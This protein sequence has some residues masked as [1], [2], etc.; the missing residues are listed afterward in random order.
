MR[1]DRFAWLLTLFTHLAFL[2]MLALLAGC[3]NR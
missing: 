1:P 3:G 2:A